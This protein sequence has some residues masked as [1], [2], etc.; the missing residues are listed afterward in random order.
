MMVTTYVD[1]NQTCPPGTMDPISLLNGQ[2]LLS[3]NDVSASG[4]GQTWG[5]SRSYNNQ[6]GGNFDFGNGVN[7]LIYQ[8][9][10]LYDDGGAV[11][12]VR[13]GQDS[14]WFD[15]VESGY[16]ARYGVL[17]TLSY[18]ATTDVFTWA[19]T[20]GAIEQYAGFDSPLAGKLLSQ[21]T[22]GGA[23]IY[24]SY[25]GGQLSEMTRSFADAD[26]VT[27]TESYV[28]SYIDSGD[29]AGHIASVE[30]RRKAETSSG[31]S[32]SSSSSS[33]GATDFWYNVRRALYTY[34]GSSDASGALNDL[35]TV[36][37]QVPDEGTG[38]QNESTLYYRYYRDSAGDTGF[39]H[40][41]KY[42]LNAEAFARLTAAVGNPFTAS[43]EQ[44]AEFAD[45]YFEYDN[46]RRATRE[47]VGGGTRTYTY[48]Y[49]ESS[50][51][52]G[53]NNWTYQTTETRPDASQ[54]IFYMNYIGEPMLDV[55]TDGTNQWIT[56]RQFD[57]NYN[58]VKVF[59]PSAINLSASP[60]YDPTQADLAVQ[61]LTGSGLITTT[62][63]Y[64]G[65]SGPAGYVQQVA[66][67]QGTSGT[68]IVQ[69][70]YQYGSNTAGG[71]TIY[72][73]SQTTQYS[74]DA[75]T[76]A[77]VTSFSYQYYPGTNQKLEQ[78]KTLPV[79][80]TSQN[81]SGVAATQ[82]EQ[83]DLY[84]NMTW[85]QGP[86]GYVDYFAYDIV[87]GA[88]TQMVEDVDNTQPGFPTDWTRPAALAAPLFLTTDYK[89][90]DLG[91]TTQALGPEH[92]VDGVGVRTATWTVY[93]DVQHQILSAQGY[94]TGLATSYDFTLVNPVSITQNDL[95]RRV[96]DSIQAVRASTA[97][98]LTGGDSFDQSTWVRW[99]HNIH[100]D[101]S[102]LVATRAY[103]DIPAS[104]VGSPGVNYDQT[105]YGYDSMSRPNRVVSPGGTITRSIFD[106][107]DRPIA[108]WVGTN[109]SGA[110]DQQPHG[111]GA[112]GNNM[113]QV[114]ANT[115]SAG[116][117]CTQPNRVTQFVDDTTQRVTSYTLDFRNRVTVID[118]EIDFYRVNTYDNLNNLIQ[119]DRYDTSSNG[120]LIARNQSLFDNQSRVYQSITYSVDPSTGTVGNALTT[121][122]WY[123]EAG[124]Q[125][126]TLPAGS[127]MFTKM[128]YDSQARMYAMYQGYYTGSGSESYS[129]V[130][131]ITSNNK[132]FEQTL[133][134]FDEA[135]NAIEIDSYQ[136]FHNATG[137]G[138]LQFPYS[139]TQPLARVSYQANWF[140]GIGR[141]T[142]LGNYGTN[143]NGTFTRPDAA[144][145]SSDTILVT[146]QAY[147]SAGN[148]DRTVDS[149]GI[150]SQRSYNALGSV[151]S[152]I[153]NYTGGS[154]GNDI[155]VTI[156]MAYN[157]DGNL[158]T[159]TACNPTTGD[160]VTHY[161]YGTTL[162][163]SKI[164]SNGLLRATIYPDAVD[165]TDRVA[166]SYN[167]Q[168]QV[169]E[170]TDQNG[171]AH[172]YD[173]DLLG[174]ITDDIIRTLGTGVDG[175]VQRISS[176]YEV[177]GLVEFVTSYADS[178]GGTVVNQVQNVYNG[179]Q[180]L[181][182]QYQQHD[183]AVNTSSSLSVDY[184]YYDGSTNTIR[185]STLV[186]P[187]NRMIT[188][189]Y[190]SGDD[191]ALSRVTSLFESA[192]TTSYT[193]LG[194]A[195]FVE[196]NYSQPN[197]TWQLTGGSDPANPYSGIDRFGRVIDCR[198]AGAG[199]DVEDVQ[200]GYDQLSNRLW[201]HNTVA[202]TGGN[203][204]LYAYDQV[205]RL[206][207]MS[208]GDLTAGNT[209]ITN[210]SLAQQWRL[211]A[212]G[213][214]SNFVNTDLTTP[215]NSL[216]Q[217][218]T[219]NPVNEIAAIGQRYG[220]AWAQPA[221]DR[222]GN[223][224]AI[225]QPNTPTNAFTGTY[226]AW[227][228]LVTL[229]GTASYRYDGL[230]R[231]TTTVGSTVR[232]YYYSSD[233]QVLEERVGGA[234]SPERQFVWGIRYIDDLIV[235][236]R[237]PS[238]SG[239]LAEHLY[240][241]Q[242]DNWN[243][244]AITDTSGN[245]QERYRYTAY[246][247]PTFLD[248][249]FNPLSSPGT[250]Q[251]ETLYAAYR[252]DN[253]SALY[254][255]R[256]RYL[257]S[258]IGAWA[259]N[260]PIEFYA[261]DLNL[262]R[263]TANGPLNAVDPTGYVDFQIKP[264]DV[265]S[266]GWYSSAL[267]GRGEV[268]RTIF[269][270]LAV[271]WKTKASGCGGKVMF[272]IRAEIRILLDLAEIQRLKYDADQAYGHEQAH[273]Q[274]LITILH[275]ASSVLADVEGMEFATE[276]EATTAAEA[277][278]GKF[279]TAVEKAYNL[280]AMHKGKDPKSPPKGKG[281]DPKGTRPKNPIGR[282]AP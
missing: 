54:R 166:Q 162:A 69:A 106:T 181:T 180:Q 187:N 26:G 223:M 84:G 24:M 225:P 63:Y 215:A 248:P 74:D 140:D 270:D 205:Q 249:A 23:T 9:P 170:T 37:R 25:S 267:P 97:G 72:P 231:R 174:R 31:T 217:Q 17:D 201:R 211:D 186:Y 243:V 214:W 241:I 32:S 244:T 259:T 278:I 273:A 105:G 247:L 14:E 266:M 8:W 185:P 121:N 161:L 101:A 282:Q 134:T 3:E 274:N 167:R 77:I 202:P 65:T 222:A 165:A 184:T 28:Y 189:M 60:V 100:N 213:N 13:A 148:Q 45:S 276:K 7:W 192:N 99:T 110:T 94:A 10:Y 103:C 19:S 109:D 143:E 160:Q 125:I 156:L 234:T 275:N 152:T 61:T 35:Q 42:V 107:D 40:G 66:I 188:Y 238:G 89:C 253:Q 199:S 257:N 51:A 90:D 58:P 27:T 53:P 280:D 175:S 38:W 233:W 104:G 123:D 79:I 96:V 228:R 168:G 250:I 120:N 81:G 235:R 230:N 33:S 87:T 83:Y 127:Q 216:D 136:R 265:E 239:S 117:D 204:E 108:T 22:P 15:P 95:A 149:A 200:Y 102:Q 118:G 203:D 113:V 262:Y 16:A 5:H 218:R 182:N 145:P 131:Q 177:R 207:D 86:K 227:N 85:E 57:D 147:D 91:R 261:D 154:P 176:S 62:S 6:M 197:I 12:V 98:P 137:N 138:A 141:R 221:Y 78:M 220:A 55:V 142:A 139:G 178:G 146:T 43:D 18:N 2:V 44:V 30:L 195:T 68:P 191:N 219:S 122:N 163:D 279:E 144:P 50:F 48:V 169:I 132:I 272:T 56:Y 164:A 92:A 264:E 93:L 209:G 255:V 251:W 135:G 82:Q 159:L 254:Y 242:D 268:G 67:Q 256:N 59:S 150:V 269:A 34:Y 133:T 172:T 21:T 171:T 263:Y 88:T 29:N 258:A 75:N 246:G 155:D 277:A 39:A 194:L 115:Y 46:Q 126:K 114:T 173:Y 190:A 158:V 76:Q 1:Y 198:W 116:C 232:D 112:R 229:T 64:D 49:T 281:A 52:D 151:L 128:F 193:Y 130:G 153:S 236:D 224:T 4:F 260:D 71:V 210:T 206:V 111:G 73:L 271:P 11:I 36:T 237:A 157:A 129:E 41:M 179:F 252:W 20:S 119:V 124:N 80:P 47:D 70:Q 183:G 196:T 212:T 245:V 208:R 240:A 226:D